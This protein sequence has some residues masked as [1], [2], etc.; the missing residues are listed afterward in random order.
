[1]RHAS[2]RTMEDVEGERARVW[3]PQIERSWFVKGY[4]T[5]GSRPVL[6]SARHLRWFVCDHNQLF[7]P[8]PNNLDFSL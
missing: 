2:N 3:S 6:H 8:R 7:F 4:L 1:M 5:L